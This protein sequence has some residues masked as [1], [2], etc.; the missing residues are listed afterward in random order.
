MKIDKHGKPH[1]E[2]DKL[3]KP[4]CEFDKYGKPHWGLDKLGKPSCEFVLLHKFD[5]KP[6]LILKR[7]DQSYRSVL[8]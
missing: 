5:G 8:L 6:N 1:W 2:L 4:S 3:G 7:Y